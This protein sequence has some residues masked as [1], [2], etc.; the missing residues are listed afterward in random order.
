[1][2][3]AV[4]LFAVSGI[5]VALPAR[6]Q[7]LPE[8]PMSAPPETTSADKDADG[9]VA[10]PIATDEAESPDLPPARDT[11]GG[12]FAISVGGGIVVPFGP[13]ESEIPWHDT[14][15]HGLGID[16]E[17]AVGVSRSVMV[18]VWLGASSLGRGDLCQDCST[19]TAAGGP[20]LRVHLVQGL[21][22]DPWASVGVGL[23]SIRV[24]ADERF[25]Y[26][27]L[28]WMR[29]TLGADWYASP[30]IAVGPFVQ[31]LAGASVIRPQS[32]P[33]DE[34]PFDDRGSVYWMFSSGLRLT[35]AA[36]AR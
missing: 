15:G 33:V 11:L 8:P 9:L 4:A 12:R 5:L 17:P 35:L 26:L 24:S 18:G 29:A 2:R 21:K 6:G 19:L 22:L 31:L 3:L 25:D 36:P 20:L 1:M 27:G 14:T 16:L 7:S 32:S 13:L 28:D 23:R 30:H 10:T 34:R